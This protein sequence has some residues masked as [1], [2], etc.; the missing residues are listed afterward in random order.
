MEEEKQKLGKRITP[1]DAAQVPGSVADGL[2][3][4]ERVASVSTGVKTFPNSADEQERFGKSGLDLR[5]P[6]LN[7]RGEP[8]M[9]TRPRKARKL[10][11]QGRAK[12]VG[13]NP[14]TIQVLYGTD[15]GYAHIGYSTM[16]NIGKKNEK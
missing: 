3:R 6:V 14:F 13:Y 10:I 2:N 15:A 16:E 12:V 11:E 7:M 8:S 5:V 4:S 9:P 1:R